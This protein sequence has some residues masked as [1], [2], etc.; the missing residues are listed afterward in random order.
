MPWTTT[1]SLGV[2]TTGSPLAGMTVAW[3]PRRVMNDVRSP[4]TSTR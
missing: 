2:M 4:L 1:S 3:P